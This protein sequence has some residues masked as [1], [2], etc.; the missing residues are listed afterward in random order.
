MKA[1][2]ER[3]KISVFIATSM[4]GY[5]ARENGDLDWLINFSPPT[6]TNEEKDYGYSKFF[7]SV[8]VLVMGRHSYETVMTFDLWP[9]Q[10]KRVIVLS[11]SLT[12]VC[13]Q[14]ELYSGEINQL[15]NQLHTE[16]IKHIYVDGGVTISHFLNAGLIDHVT[17]SLIPVV[18]GTGIPLFNYV[19]HDKWCRLVSSQVYSNGLVQLKYDVIQPDVSM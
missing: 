17:I 12:S 19:Q 10:G 3:P 13:E 1:I 18:L 6:E 5:I 14:A 4:D 15:V 11:A 7:S 2:K 9:Y 8:D 16:G